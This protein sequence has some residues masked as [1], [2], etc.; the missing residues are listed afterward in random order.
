MTFTKHPPPEVPTVGGDESSPPSSR[1]AW[2]IAGA[3][4]AAVV[5]AVVAGGVEGDRLAENAERRPNQAPVATAGD[6]PPASQWN[7]VVEDIESLLPETIIRTA[8]G[9]AVIA[10]PGGGGPAIWTTTNGIDW[11]R[12]DLDFAPHGL[13]FDGSH[14]LAYRDATLW[15]F[16]K[17]DTRWIVEQETEL[18]VLVRLGYLSHRPSVTPFRQTVLMQTPE[19]ELY[20]QAE[21]GDFD[22]VVPLGVWSREE[23]TA[24]DVATAPRVP[25]HCRPPR[26]GSVDYVPIIEVGGN[27]LALV[28]GGDGRP[29]GI[30]PLCE[31]SPWASEDG[32]EWSRQTPSTPFVSGAYI[33]DVAATDAGVIAVGGVGAAWPAMWVLDDGSTWVRRA[34]LD[35]DGFSNYQPTQIEAGPAGW[36]IT[37]QKANSPDVAAWISVD[38]RCWERVPDVIAA[39]GIAVGDEEIVITSRDGSVWVAQPTR[40]CS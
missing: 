24:W 21:N 39:H 33:Y 22:I 25:D 15:S 5:L 30:W 7:L 28:S 2:P 23:Q 1:R 3:V 6:P 16:A 18:P 20:A 13:A 11:S 35:I 26:A 17:R 12:T 36:I 31:P 8:D 14:L 32:R 4:I 10:G 27:L 40:G 19:G 29:H 34:T 37:G 9:F 38:G